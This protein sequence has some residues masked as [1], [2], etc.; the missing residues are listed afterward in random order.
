MIACPVCGHVGLMVKPYA[1]WPPPDGVQLRPPYEDILG[2]P[3]YEVCPQCGF[4][5]GFDDN[6]GDGVAGASFG[7][8]LT[9]WEAEGRPRFTTEEQELRDRSRLEDRHGNPQ[10]RGLAT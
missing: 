1:I 3:S 5:F 6:P 4:E 10:N 7:E 9:E 8:Y 2:S